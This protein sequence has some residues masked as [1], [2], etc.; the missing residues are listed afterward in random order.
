MIL[1]CLLEA[2]EENSVLPVSLSDPGQPV[3]EGQT[4]WVL[5][6]ALPYTSCVS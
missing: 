3:V 1:I 2:E 5:I 6:P 4:A